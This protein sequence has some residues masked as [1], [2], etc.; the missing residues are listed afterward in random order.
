MQTM[1]QELAA[2]EHGSPFATIQSQI[3]SGYA[4]DGLTLNPCLGTVE[5]V[6]QL[7]FR[8]CNNSTR[9]Q[10]TKIVANTFFP[11]CQTPLR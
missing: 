8:P 6:G 1:S 10:T 7:Y 9:G 2:V 11:N 5:Q 4:G 3:I